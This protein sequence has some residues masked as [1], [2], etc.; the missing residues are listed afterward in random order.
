MKVPVLIIAWRRPDKV[1]RVISALRVV[2]PE[3]VFV[4]CDGPRTENEKDIKLVLETRRILIEEI[5]WN[6]SIKKRFHNTNQGCRIGVSG[7]IN[8]FF[9]HV[10]QGIILEDDCM[11]HPDFFS[12]TSE[13][14]DFYKNDKRI[15]CISGNNFQ[16]GK[17]HGDG[18]Y[19]FSKYPHCWGWATWKDRWNYY[20]EELTKWDQLKKSK[21]I[22]SIFPNRKERN[23]FK[24]IFDK[25][26]FE[27]QPD[28]WAYRWFF[29][30]QIYSG[31]TILPN[32][33]LVKNIGFDE[34]STHTKEGLAPN[35]KEIKKSNFN[36][37]PI[38]HPSF[39][40]RSIDADEYTFKKRFL[41]DLHLRIFYK[42]SRFLKYLKTLLF[43]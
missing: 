28:S 32:E 43:F 23:Y 31:L 41:V 24:K 26:K 6:C 19:Y 22:Y 7:A 5:D 16:E 29:I 25:L 18:S 13:L 27:N 39:I 11:P 37:L 42:V 30:C 14:L 9:E 8:W 21:L 38:K 33:N 12:F 4:A 36:I 34:E 40:V 20:K 35:I 1:K 3:K 10:D 2:K 15:W 17:W